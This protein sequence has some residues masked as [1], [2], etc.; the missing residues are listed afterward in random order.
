[1][2]NKTPSF[3]TPGET[4]PEALAELRA[5][6]ATLKADL[7]RLTETLGKTAREGVKD[8]ADEAEAAFENMGEWTEGQYATLRDT[9]QAQ[10]LTSCAVAT[11]VGFLLGVLLL[12]R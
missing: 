6:L 11:G 9:I 4:S 1:M 10:P 5:D 2:M 3:E 8:V 12:R 7:A